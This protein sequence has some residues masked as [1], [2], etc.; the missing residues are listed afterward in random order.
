MSERSA[1]RSRQPEEGGEDSRTLS[2]AHPH[3]EGDRPLSPSQGNRGGGNRGGNEEVSALRQVDDRPSETDPSSSSFPPREP[4]E[5]PTVWQP[6]LDLQQFLQDNQLG[7]PLDGLAGRDRTVAVSRLIRALQDEAG[8]FRMRTRSTHDTA[9]D[10]EQEREAHLAAQHRMHAAHAVLQNVDQMGHYLMTNPTPL[11]ARR[12][13]NTLL[14]AMDVFERAHR[15]Y[16]SFPLTGMARNV[17][18]DTHARLKATVD[19]ITERVEYLNRPLARGRPP[20]QREQDAIQLA[21]PVQGAAVQVPAA[22]GG[23]VPRDGD[24]RVRRDREES[25]SQDDYRSADTSQDEGERTGNVAGGNGGR[26]RAEDLVRVQQVPIEHHPAPRRRAVEAA[27][28]EGP[29]RAD[30]VRVR[31]AREEELQ[32]PPRGQATRGVAQSAGEVFYREGEARSQGRPYLPEA[33]RWDESLERR[34][35]V[36]DRYVT[37]RRF[38]QRGYDESLDRPPPRGRERERHDRAGDQIPRRHLFRQAS[39]ED[40]RRDPSRGDRARREP[41]RGEDEARRYQERDRAFWDYDYEQPRWG[42][43]RPSQPDIPAYDYGS[44]RGRD[45]AGPGSAAYTGAAAWDPYE[46][47]PGYYSRF[48]QDPFYGQDTFEP[49][50]MSRDE[51]E[52]RYG[53]GRGRSQVVNVKKFSGKYEEWPEWIQSFKEHILENPTIGAVEAWGH[54]REKLTKDAYDVIKAFENTHES[55]M[56]ALQALNRAFAQPHKIVQH[57][58]RELTGLR[59]RDDTKS[60]LLSMHYAQVGILQRLNR[61]SWPIEYRADQYEQNAMLETMGSY[62]RSQYD[63]WLQRQGRGFYPTTDQFLRWVRD[64]IEDDI[65]RSP[66]RGGGGYQ[67]PVGSKKKPPATALPGNAQGSK[68]SSQAKKAPGKGQKSEGGSAKSKFS[69]GTCIGCG[70]GGSHEPTACSKIK[71][72]TVKERWVMRAESKGCSNCLRAGHHY[73]DCDNPQTCHCKSRHHELLHD[74][75]GPP[76]EVKKKGGKGAKKK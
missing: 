70:Q 36:D 56:P 55:L 3:S 28:P 14:K 12:K 53:A 6:E 68:D 29:L 21:P 34:A 5:S 37:S 8:S 58:W 69:K 35:P 45:A 38:D 31:Q 39:Q 59:P 47:G 49:P 1:S 40:R 54:L 9:A 7:Q 76:P 32:M 4:R 41:R 52:R 20:A 27:P 64:K 50:R 23:A 10:H 72:A 13:G 2:E 26:H 15:D 67:P 48:E 46:D 44:G 18:A 19:E 43:R 71:S 61:H 65:R 11:G 60:A 17:S 74:P 33:R 22:G 57:I 75:D 63:R 16:T 24:W 62:Y 42:D 51:Y 25:D 66:R 30:Q 73:K